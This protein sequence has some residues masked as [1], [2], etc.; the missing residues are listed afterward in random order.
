MLGHT[1]HPGQ[2]AGVFVWSGVGQEPGRHAVLRPRGPPE[3]GLRQ[4]SGVRGLVVS[5]ERLV[6][7]H[8]IQSEVRDRLA[9]SG[10]LLLQ[11]LQAPGLIRLQTSILLAPSITALFPYT[12]RLADQSD[13]LTLGQ[14]HFG[15]PDHPQYLFCCATFPAHLVLLSRLRSTGLSQSA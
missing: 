3:H 14:P 1:H 5:Q 4:C 6:Q 15:F 12:K 11:V 9:K 2:S 10:V 13:L 7:N 8:L